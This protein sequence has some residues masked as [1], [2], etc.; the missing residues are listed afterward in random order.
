MSS[1]NKSPPVTLTLDEFGS[2]VDKSGKTR[3]VTRFT[4]KNAKNTT[5]QA[6]NYGATITSIKVADKTGKVE[7]IITGFDTIDEYFGVKN[8][9]YGASVGRVANRIAGGR[10]NVDGVDYQLAKNN[11][12]VNHLHGGDQGFDKRFWNYH[13]NGTKVILTYLS[14]D[15]EEN[16]PGD[17]LATITFELTSN[18]EFE[19]DYKASVSRTTPVNLTN[20]SYFNL[21]GHGSGS[22]ELF[23][24]E[25]T[26]NAD[27]YTEVEQFIPTGKLV[28]VSGTVFDFRVAR[29]LGDAIKS[30]P[31]G[32]G[33]DINYCINKASAQNIEFVASA[34]HPPSG[35]VMEVYSNQPG[36]QFY[37]GNALPETDTSNGK[38]AVYRKHG[39]FCLE[40]QKFPDAVHHLNFP[41]VLVRPGEQY[42]HVAVFKFFIRN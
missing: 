19:I 23:K 18:N 4:W 25:I 33:Y 27:K 21:G 10:L 16:Y 1:C 28:N 3:N 8:R 38:G 42:H 22:V 34:F 5:I 32:K 7:D 17:V 14:P 29:N 30:T 11:N 35:R 13:I 12:G 40:T 36:V 24:H 41:D 6:I 37:T 15:L 9:F 20:H 39:A 31:E 2:Y 26:I